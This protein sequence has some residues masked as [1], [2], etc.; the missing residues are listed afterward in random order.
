MEAVRQF[1]RW[2]ER[3]ELQKS[4]FILLV[5]AGVTLGGY[6]VFML[7]MGT[8]TPMVVVTS[9]SMVPVLQPGDLLVLQGRAPEQIHVGDII[10]F[11]DNEWSTDAPIV[12]RVVEIEVIDGTYHFRTKGDANALPDPGTRTP[13][14]IVGVVVARVPWVGNIS[15]FLKTP[16]GIAVIVGLFLLILFVPSG[17][18]AGEDNGGDVVDEPPTDG[19]RGAAG[20]STPT[21]ED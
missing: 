11:Q 21:T 5:V 14:E 8:T 2:E 17:A 1:L 15:M 6:G 13:D 7:S 9:E 16:L 20:E 12:H 18:E 10:V 4:L 19:G 3:S